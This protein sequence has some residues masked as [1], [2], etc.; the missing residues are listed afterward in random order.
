MGRSATGRR[1][2]LFAALALGVPGL[3]RAQING[4]VPVLGILA[5]EP[6]P[7]AIAAMFRDSLRALGHFD[8]TD[9]RLQYRGGPPERLAQLAQQ[10][11]RLKAEVIVTYGGAPVARAAS[12]A[13]RNIPIV[14]AD[15]E[16]AVVEGLVDN[17]QRP[18]GR[19]TGLSVFESKVHAM[20]LRLLRE[21]TPGVRR[22]AVL[23]EPA[24][25]RSAFQPMQQTAQSF[26]L[27]LQPLAAANPEEARAALGTAKRAGSEALLVLP[28]ALF[29]A[30]RQS[31]VDLTLKEAW[32]AM[33]TDRSFVEAGGIIS[34]GADFAA[35][36]REAARFALSLLQGARVAE[37]PVEQAKL[38]LALNLRTARARRLTVPRSLVSRAARIVP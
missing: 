37:L 36:R 12:E 1:G 28:S 17:P 23:H 25:P 13:T 21:L 34:Y 16:D 19:A 33:F 2:F 38:E 35:M 11:A 10:L 27:T 8:G 9:L 24:T 7:E 30:F 3:A 32:T 5:S 4:R 22:I 31:L 20:R 14:F 15:A 26:R 6:S 29:S 18:S